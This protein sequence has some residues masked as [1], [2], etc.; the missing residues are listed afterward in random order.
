M[1][2]KSISKELYFELLSSNRSELSVFSSATHFDYV[3]TEWGFKG[4][5][6][7]FIKAVDQLRFDENGESWE[8][9]YYKNCELPKQAELNQP[10]EG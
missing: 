6:T 2:W 7:A 10:Y 9:R 4:A 5:D 8:Y 1:R 3:M